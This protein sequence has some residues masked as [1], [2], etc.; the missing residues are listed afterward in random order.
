MALR[1]GWRVLLVKNIIQLKTYT[2]TS[3]N[4]NL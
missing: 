2:I 4:Y 3:N 1:K